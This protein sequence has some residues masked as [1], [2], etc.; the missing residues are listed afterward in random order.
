[1]ARFSSTLISEVEA[2]NAEQVILLELT[3][4]DG[5]S[6]SETRLTT[7]STD[8]DATVDSVLRTF[9]GA[10]GLVTWGG[11]SEGS[12]R[13][14]GV[15][16]R[17]SGVDSSIISTLLSNFFKGQPA[18]MWIAWLNPS[19]G[20]IID[21]PYKVFR[22]FQLEEYRL[23]EDWGEGE[24]AGQ[25]SIRTTLASRRRL[26]ERVRILPTVVSHN[27]MLER[28]G[29]ST[30]D[31]FWDVLPSIVGKEIFWGRPNPDP[32]S[33]TKPNPDAEGIDIRRG[34]VGSF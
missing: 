16:V 3:F 7:A 11:Q 26:T 18:Q 20:Q 22:G 21:S 19:T 10:G 29:L 13:K 23:T 1:M 30:G 27:R 34:D 6:T 9:T 31:T 14:A 15:E 8:I 2:E 32:A 24:E 5:A 28:A 4:F 17:L 12:D 33:G 25:A